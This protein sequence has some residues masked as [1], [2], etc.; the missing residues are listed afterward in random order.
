MK[1]RTTGLEANVWRLVRAEAAENAE[2]GSRLRAIAYEDRGHF[3]RHPG[4][5]QGLY[6]SKL[7]EKTQALVRDFLH[8][9]VWVPAFAGMT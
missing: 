5:G 7:S 9:R 1:L 3:F 8:Q 2:E 6:A 4:E